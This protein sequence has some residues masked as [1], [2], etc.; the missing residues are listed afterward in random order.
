M[1]KLADVDYF[2]IGPGRFKYTAVMRNGKRVN[3]GSR[4]YQQYKDSVPR[5]LGGG[6]WSD[7]DHMDKDRRES[8]RRRH[9]GILNRDGKPA[10]KVKYSPS[11]FA[12]NYLW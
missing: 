10:Y 11:W 12:Y 9:A 5:R 1:N 3:F 4:D 7:K 2:D 8:Y 6:Q